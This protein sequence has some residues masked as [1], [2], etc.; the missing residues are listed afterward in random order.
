MSKKSI[1]CAIERVTL[2]VNDRL[3]AST[4]LNGGSTA[5]IAVSA[6][7]AVSAL[8]RM[9]HKMNIQANVSV[10]FPIF[11]TLILRLW[12]CIF[13]TFDVEFIRDRKLSWYIV[14]LTCSL[15]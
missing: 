12:H 1:L 2:I 4:V 11:F 15:V 6:A 5:M 13:R 3:G 14:S 8:A 10:F 7:S 9:M